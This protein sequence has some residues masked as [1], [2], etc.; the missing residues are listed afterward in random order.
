M[1]NVWRITKGEGVVAN[2]EN[3]NGSKFAWVTNILVTISIA[4]STVTWGYIKSVD[5]KMFNHL[6]NATIHIPRETVTSKDE[7]ILYQTMRDKQMQDLKEMICEI[8]DMMKKR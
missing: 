1:C 7:F 4:V 5:D 3:N 8:K 6:T 2:N